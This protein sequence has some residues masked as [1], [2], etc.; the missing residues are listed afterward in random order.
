MTRPLL[1]PAAFEQARQLYQRYRDGDLLEFEQ[2]MD[3]T[4]PAQILLCELDQAFTAL[5]AQVDAIASQFPFEH[6]TDPD[7]EGLLTAAYAAMDDAHRQ[8]LAQF[9]TLDPRSAV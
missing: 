2:E 1:T 4:L 9:V 5:R 7:L 8:F 6:E 3:A